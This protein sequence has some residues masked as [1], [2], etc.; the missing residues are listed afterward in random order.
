[1]FNATRVIHIKSILKDIKHKFMYMY[2]F[3][4][5]KHVFEIYIK[6]I[7]IIFPY[8]RFIIFIKTIIL[9][10]YCFIKYRLI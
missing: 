5:I 1:M 9:C 8:P 4:I 7:K 6:Y 3:D 2:I 10:Y